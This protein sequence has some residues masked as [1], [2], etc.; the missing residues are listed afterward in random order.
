MKVFLAGVESLYEENKPLVVGGYNLISF[1]TINKKSSDIV[2]NSKMFLLDSGAY[3]FMSNSKKGI[4]WEEYVERYATFIKENDIKYY[5]ELDID[6]VVGYQKVLEYRKKLEGITGRRCVPV[7]HKTRGLQ[8]YKRMCAEYDYVAI[9]GIVS[10]EIKKAHYGAF[11]M[12][13]DYAHGNGA[14]VHGLGFTDT[15]KLSTYH[16]DSVD[17][18]SWG[19]GRF[20]YIFHFT[21]KD[22]K[23]N[24]KPKGKR[25]T[26]QAELQ[27]VNIKEWIKFQKYAETHL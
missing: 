1:Y 2:K 27:A 8:E 16:F 24:P 26:K 15:K 6:S 11:P 19:W 7:W 20:G 9:G 23:M 13:I 3:T 18:T 17:S 12:L 21:G 4:N 14:K 22:M 25:C 5:F 10:G